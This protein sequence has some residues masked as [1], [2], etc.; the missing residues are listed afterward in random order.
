MSAFV[1]LFS[2]A[3]FSF[4][5]NK[6]LFLKLFTLTSL[7]VAA[8]FT[9]TH[10]VTPLSGFT[11]S[12]AALFFESIVF[13]VL[14]AVIMSESDSLTITQT[15]FIG[16]ASI[17]LLE[18]DTL[19]SFILSFEALSIISFVLVSHIED[20]NQAEGAV[21][22]FISGAIATGL[23]LF[24]L[25]LFTLDGHDFTQPLSGTFSA[26]STAALLIVLMGIFYKL[27]IVPMHSWAV[28]GYSLIR[29]S[30][31]AI[32]SGVAKTVVAVG[33]FKIF[34]PFL[35]IELHVSTPLL[36]I[37]SVIT[38]TLGNVL[39]LYQTNVAKILAYSSIAHAGYMLLAFV[40]VK[41]SYA[42]YGLLYLAVAYIFMQSAAFLWLGLFQRKVVT[43]DM[44]KG[45]G[46]KHP[47]IAFFLTVQLFSLAGI[48]LLAGF[49]GKAV[50]VYAVVDAG[51]WMVALIALLNSALSVGYYAWIVKHLY[52]DTANSEAVSLSWSVSASV[53]QIILLA[54]TLYFGL[55]AFSIF[56]VSF[57]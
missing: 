44:L 28:D 45:L 16:S 13:I 29:P 2:A 36:I 31:A 41:S 55:Y 24:G 3:I 33:A 1:I 12:S 57:G 56:G 35:Q 48:P 23:I 4:A 19:L 5:I 30:H 18:S 10:H 49:L 8:Y 15:L 43:L 47:S 21:K 32:L 42:P 50:A 34:L 39:A 7:L 52:F 6:Q 25:A 14:F 22:M 38:M 27:T 54:G 40:A 46:A 9:L 20:K 37:L 11:L 51:F 17:L 26:Y 53:S